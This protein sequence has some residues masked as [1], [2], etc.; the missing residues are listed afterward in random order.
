M[1]NQPPTDYMQIKDA[2]LIILHGLLAAGW[3]P[4]DAL[5]ESKMLAEQFI[6]EDDVPNR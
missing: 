6:G 3:N 4:D 5:R 1:T 2:Q